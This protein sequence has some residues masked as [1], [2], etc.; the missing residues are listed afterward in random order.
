[1]VQ[2]ADGLKKYY[3]NT[4]SNSKSDNKDE[5]IVTDNGRSKMHYFHPGPK[6]IMTIVS[7]EII[8]MMHLLELGALMEHFHYRLKQ[9]ENNTWHP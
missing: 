2:E 9:I 1:M 5:S 3:T 6:T 8:L 7:A 4:D